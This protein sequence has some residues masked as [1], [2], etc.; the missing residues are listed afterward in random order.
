LCNK[1]CFRGRQCLD[2]SGLLRRA[3]L[4]RHGAAQFDD[5][6]ALGRLPQLRLGAHNSIA[7]AAPK[8]ARVERRR[9]DGRGSRR[10]H[11]RA[12]DQPRRGHCDAEQNQSGGPTHQ[13][14]RH[15]GEPGMGAR[16]TPSQR[17]QGQARPGAR[18][19]PHPSHRLSFWA[20]PNSSR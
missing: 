1:L 20:F 15:I 3:L 17:C 13:R 7:E 11:R 19:Y 2:G 8:L 14:R 18:E 4:R 16:K 12:E 9:F 6:L 5:D 10:G